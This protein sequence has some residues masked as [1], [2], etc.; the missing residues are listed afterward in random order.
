MLETLDLT[1]NG[2]G[3]NTREFIVP[4]GHYFMMGDNRDNSADSRF[5]VGFVPAENLVGRANIIFFSIAGGASPL[6]IWRWPTE[7]RPSRILDWV[8]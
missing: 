6:E 4:E 8:D 5:S 2:I 7:V 1:A 3:D